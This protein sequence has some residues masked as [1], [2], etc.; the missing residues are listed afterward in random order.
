MIERMN[1]S[2]AADFSGKDT[3]SICKGALFHDVGKLYTRNFVLTKQTGLSE[4]EKEHI[5]T[6]TR[7]GYEA[8]K[9]GLKDGEQETVKNILLYHHERVDGSGYEHMAE[10]PLYVQIVSICD[11]FDALHSDRSYRAGLPKEV[12]MKIIREGK[13]GAF[14]ENIIEYLAQ[15]TENI[16]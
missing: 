4:E 12:C 6:H 1:S 7:Y 5:K 11:V 3:D 2:N 9:S 16:D 8:I 13:S 14:D 10:L 15:I